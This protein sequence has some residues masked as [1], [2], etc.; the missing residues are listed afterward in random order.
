VVRQQFV[1]FN[2]ITELSYL[3]CLHLCGV[4]VRGSQQCAAQNAAV[5]SVCS[6][7]N[8]RTRSNVACLVPAR[9]SK[10][11]RAPFCCQH[12]SAVS[13]AP[14][15]CT[16]A[17]RADN[18]RLAYNASCSARHLATQRARC[19]LQRVDSC[20][21]RSAQRVSCPTTVDR[22]AFFHR[23]VSALTNIL[24]E[25]TGQ[26]LPDTNRQC[27]RDSTQ[28]TAYAASTLRFAYTLFQQIYD[29]LCALVSIRASQSATVK[30][31]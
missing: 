31:S 11:Q 4:S 3:V 2:Y 7:L 9:R 27:G 6:V 8:R 20:K 19:G 12:S 15:R 5:K 30:S 10:R 28:A 24:T 29:K 25:G 23:H 14:A 26:H 13:A 21:R 17:Q 1:S 16:H 18:G 22:R